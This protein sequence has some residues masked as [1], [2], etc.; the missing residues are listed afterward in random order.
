MDEPVTEKFGTAVCVRSDHAG[1]AKAVVAALGDPFRL[2]DDPQRACV[3]VVVRADLSS[4]DYEAFA[5]VA[6]RCTKMVLVS[7]LVDELAKV[8]FVVR[9]VVALLPMTGLRLDALVAAV[10]S[11]IGG[12]AHL[13]P[14]LTGALVA[15][16]QGQGVPRRAES[17]HD[18]GARTLSDR[19]RAMLQCLS[20]G[21]G[22]S[23]TAAALG[24]SA[25]TVKYDLAEVLTRHDC[26]TRAQAVAWAIR[27]GAI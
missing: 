1:L 14:Q 26:R 6:G 8:E 11:V 7:D 18:S 3:L 25:R 22:T 23:E 24:C 10:Q 5:H 4:A 12:A 19:Q 27:T 16:L 17:D 13:P 21:L 2:T 9:G 15:H 20:E